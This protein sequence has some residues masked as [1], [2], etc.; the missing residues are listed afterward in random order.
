MFANLNKNHSCAYKH[1]Y[2]RYPC[3]YLEVEMLTARILLLH[4]SF[5]LLPLFSNS[6][7]TR[8]QTLAN[9]VTLENPS[10]LLP[11]LGKQAAMGGMVIS[12]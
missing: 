9:P 5:P 3:V 1:L 10:A 12:E 4:K 2:K 11:V 8:L 6:P 7:G